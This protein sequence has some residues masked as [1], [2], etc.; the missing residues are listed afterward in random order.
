MWISIRLLI[1]I[2][3][4]ALTSGCSGGLIALHDIN[5]YRQIDKPLSEDQIKE[6]I[7]EGATNA[8]LIRWSL[9]LKV[10]L[11]LNN[12]ISSGTL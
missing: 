9:Q 11:L 3:G 4:V 12:K 5:G 2:I 10:H 8:G 1:L 7:I 6:S